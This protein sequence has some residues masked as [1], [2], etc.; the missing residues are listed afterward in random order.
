M[1]GANQWT[2]PVDGRIDA[3]RWLLDNAYGF[4]PVPVMITD[5]DV[6]NGGGVAALFFHETEEQKRIRKE[7]PEKV[8]SIAPSVTGIVG[9][10]TDNGSRIFGGFHNGV[11]KDDTIRYEG[12]AYSVDVNITNYQLGSALKMNYQGLFA[13]QKIDF[14]IGESN[15]WLGADYNL[16]SGDV[17][18]GGDSATRGSHRDGSLGFKVTYDDLDNFFSP[19]QGVKAKVMYTRAAKALGGDFDY[20]KLDVDVQSHHKVGDKW[21]ASW[22]AKSVNVSDGVAYYRKPGIELRGMSGNRHQGDDIYQGELQVAYKI[23]SRWSVLGFAGAGVA[24]NPGEETK[25]KGAYGMGFRHLIA[26]QLGLKWGIDVATSMEKSTI[27][28]QFGSAW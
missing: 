3:S 25:L 26:R 5:P 20:S 11:W 17:T 10:G 22:R 2:D 7:N 19:E 16:M 9:I 24:I 28:L 27:A 21:V 6:G 23:D 12:A 13:Y 4:L 8:A 14:R 1:A 18:F 15:W